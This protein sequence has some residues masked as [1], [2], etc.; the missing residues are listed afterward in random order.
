MEYPQGQVDSQVHQPVD[1]YLSNQPQALPPHNDFSTQQTNE[2]FVMR[3]TNEFMPQKH[4]HHPQQQQQQLQPN[5][6][7]GNF[8]F[9]LNKNDFWQINLTNFIYFME[10]SRSSFTAFE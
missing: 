7:I 8:A 6:F 5:E 4:P 2:E 3:Q 1:E 10:N 9:E